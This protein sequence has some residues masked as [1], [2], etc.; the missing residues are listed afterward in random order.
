MLGEKRKRLKMVDCAF[1]SIVAKKKY[2]DAD[3]HEELKIVN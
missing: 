1:D 2:L 3:N